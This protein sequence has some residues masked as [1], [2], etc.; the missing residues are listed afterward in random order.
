MSVTRTPI[1][2]MVVTRGSD[3]SQISSDIDISLSI[4]GSDLSFQ[5]GPGQASFVLSF[6]EFLEI[7]ISKP[8]AASVN[9]VLDP[10]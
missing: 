4:D 9:I 2:P 8:I 10:P 7:L 5:T 3:N 1:C 6:N